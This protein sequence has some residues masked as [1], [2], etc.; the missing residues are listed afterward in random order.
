M[1]SSTFSGPIRV[2]TKRD[3]PDAN[4]GL[5]VLSQAY[6]TGS[7]SG[8]PIGNIDVRL[9]TLPARAQI[10][11]IV[12]DQVVAATG[13]TATISVGTAPGGSQLMA[14]VNTSAGGRF[15]GVPTAATQLAWIMNGADSPVWARV[16]IGTAA[17]TA[18][19]AVITVLYVQK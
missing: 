5:V 7:L 8:F 16:A 15:R 12:V 14:G 3:D 1:A 10:V 2:G 13:G 17:L 9:G 18:G 19:R 4:I 6:D 11:D